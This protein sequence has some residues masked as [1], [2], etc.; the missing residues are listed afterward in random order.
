[1]EDNVH[2][3]KL[4]VDAVVGPDF[5]DRK[6][7]QRCFI[8]MKMLTDFNKAAASDDLRY[9]LNYAVISNDVTRFIN[10]QNDWGSLGKASRMTSNYLI[11]KYQGIKNLELSLQTKTAHVRCDDIS[12]VVDTRNQ[13]YDILRI[14]NFKLL[15]LL[16]VFTFERLR[17][18]FVTIDLELPWTKDSLHSPPYK[19]IIDNVAEYVEN[20]NFKT[21]E[22]L[23]ESVAKVVSLDK[24]FQER[25]GL[26]ITVK[27]IKL[28]AI[29][30]TDG[31]GVSCQRT[32]KE[33]ESF[34]LSNKAVPSKGTKEFDLPIYS[35]EIKTNT[36]DR[37][38]KAYLAFGSNLGDRFQNIQLAIDLL[39][40]NPQVTVN[41]VSSL[42]ESE[43]MYFTNQN[44]FMNGCIEISTNLK[45][46][47]LLKLCKEIE[48]KELKRVKQI[49]NGPRTIDL[50]I[51][52]YL[53][54]DNEQV[55]LNDSELTIPHA[56]MLERSF[57]L[58]PLC[59]LVPFDL[60]HPLTC[61][62][63]T[64][65]LSQIYA[66]GNLED[67][68]WKLIPLPT[69]NG[70]NRFLKFKTVEKFDDFTGKTTMVSQSPSYMMCVLNT[71][72]DSF[73]DGNEFYH[74]LDKQL[75]R[76]QHMYDEGLKLHDSIIIDIGG[77][78]TRPN[79]EQIEQD[80]ELQRTVP[81]IK[82]IRS[83]K[84]W[85]QEK[86][87]ISIDT[88]RSQVAL[89]TIEAG[90]DMINDISGGTFDASMFDVVA[91]HP[92]VSYVL[93]HTRGDISNMVHMAKYDDDGLES[94]DTQTKEF[95]FYQRLPSKTGT[96]VIRSIAREISDR[97]SW[98]L[99]K[100]VRRWQLVLD[101][102]LG[103][104]KNGKNNLQ[105]IRHLSLLKNYCK[106]T[107]DGEYVNFRNI[108][109]LVGPSR[110]AFIGKI[111]DEPDASKRDF[112]TGSVIT[113][114]VG[115]GADV[116]RI[117]DYAN[118]SKAIRM[119]DAIYKGV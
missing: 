10:S 93:S 88:Y 117:H 79:S 101:P 30:N 48:Y 53:N 76:V 42:F 29:T 23:A 78:S 81:L 89:K 28:N 94:G 6:D 67:Q 105:V 58:E 7:P 9:S 24:Y 25:P 47:E 83:R 63:L 52:M 3:D 36:D 31:V 99:L 44:L 107:K 87:I 100:N 54:A 119:A 108:P 71:T 18:Q 95:M 84:D 61:E 45:P 57:V 37:W 118:C 112:A 14:S 86:I 22:S 17:K 8:T 20:C 15:T 102:G 19:G 85:E 90:A 39:K 41:Q 70:H 111:T 110:K 26:P 65:H 2:I 5:W 91:Q 33:L 96:N 109:I 40:T 115:F 35:D 104:A 103:F 80:I 38:N 46:L 34:Q 62:P 106:F 16:G 59:E 43:P 49:D 74:N 113:S 55:L 68:L 98:A 60:I 11:S 1:M 73:S 69:I 21:V 82:A 114:C 32:S 75:D 13:D 66:K 64:S 51:I 12:A 4:Q 27:I 77:C 92:E 72:P 116:I 97:Y 56:R 50:D